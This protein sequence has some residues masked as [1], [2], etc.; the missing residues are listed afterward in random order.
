M[1]FKMVALLLALLFVSACDTTNDAATGTTNGAGNKYDS[2][3]MGGDA[4]IRSSALKNPNAK[5][6]S[7]EDFVD[8]VGDRVWF[9]FNAFDINDKG[10]ATLDKQAEWLKQYSGVSITVEGHCD[11]RGTREYNLAL[12]QKRAAAVKQYL[13]AAGVDPSRIETV[14][15][16]KERPEVTGSNEEAWAQ[17]RRAVSVIK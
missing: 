14:S 11:E 9:D 7:L 12:G 8:N 4:A 16:G 10:R 1:R 5:P 15:Y 3:G 17:N 2:A 13:V 6:G